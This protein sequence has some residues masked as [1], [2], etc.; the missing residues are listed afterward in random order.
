MECWP[1]SRLQKDGVNRDRW[2]AREQRRARMGKL[3]GLWVA[4]GET[5]VESFWLSIMVFGWKDVKAELVEI[6]AEMMGVVGGQPLTCVHRRDQLSLLVAR[7][8]IVLTIM[9][10][11]LEEFVESEA[12]ERISAVKV[13]VDTSKS[14]FR[15]AQ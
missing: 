11:V 7:R 10:L 6:D 4:V 3:D 9:A 8:Q 2:L 5:D 15:S 1:S 13:L 12:L 14:A